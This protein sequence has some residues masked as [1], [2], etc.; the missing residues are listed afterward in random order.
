[1]YSFVLRTPRIDV[2]LHGSTD[3][4][5]NN[6]TATRTIE[7]AS[8]LRH[9]VANARVWGGLHYRNSTAAGL[10]LGRES[11]A[12]HSGATSS[13]SAQSTTMEAAR[14]STRAAD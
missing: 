6:W 4:T 13:Q 10:V 12:G 1:M 8:D 5:P 9:E 14:G 3:G 2:T 7:W 11:P